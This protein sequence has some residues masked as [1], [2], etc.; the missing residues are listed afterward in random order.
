MNSDSSTTDSSTSNNITSWSNRHS[1]IAMTVAI[2]FAIITFLITRPSISAI[3]ASPVSGLISLKAAARE[4]VDYA[5][6]LTDG[7]PTL[8]EFYADWCTTCQAIAPTL[9]A[10]KSDY[11]DRIDFVML[12][13][14]DPQWREP[15]AAFKATGVPQLNFLDA[16]GAPVETLIGKVPKSVLDQYLNRLLQFS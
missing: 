3:D 11:G 7:K 10:L 13:I 8:I 2:A 12:D 16:D 14:D 5:V 15:I 1:I 4:S 9:Q 6:A